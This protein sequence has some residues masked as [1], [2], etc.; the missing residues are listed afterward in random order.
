MNG[1]SYNDYQKINDILDS[2]YEKERLN[3]WVSDHTKES[4]TKKN[5]LLFTD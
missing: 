1:P 5:I 2:N 4:V 3:T